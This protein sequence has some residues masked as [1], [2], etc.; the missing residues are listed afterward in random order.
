MGDMRQ[1]MGC[2]IIDLLG[3]YFPCSG[4]IMGHG[5]LISLPC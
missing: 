3:Q 5:L 2:N 1:S 4:L